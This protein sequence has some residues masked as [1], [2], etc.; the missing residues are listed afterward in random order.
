MELIIIAF[1]IALV[2]GILLMVV[3]I[4]D[5]KK[6]QALEASKNQETQSSSTSTESS[7]TNS[8]STPAEPAN[9]QKQA[10]QLVHD[11]LEHVVDHLTHS[12]GSQPELSLAAIKSSEKS[13]SSETSATAG[14]EAGSNNGGDSANGKVC[15]KCDAPWDNSFDFCLKCSQANA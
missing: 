10:V 7:S 5:K 9:E 6:L 2:I 15:P 8:G 11:G 12:V 13:E 1:H 14:G 4:R 3:A